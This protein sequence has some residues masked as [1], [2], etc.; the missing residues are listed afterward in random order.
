MRTIFK[1]AGGLLQSTTVSRKS[2]YAPLE[3][4]TP[5]ALLDNFGVEIL[6]AGCA[7]LDLVVLGAV[8][9]LCNDPFRWVRLQVFS[10]SIQCFLAK[11]LGCRSRTFV[12]KVATGVGRLERVE[13]EY[14]GRADKRTRTRTPRD[15]T[16]VY[17]TIYDCVSM[18]KS[19]GD[20]TI[21]ESARYTERQDLLIYHSAIKTDGTRVSITMT[22][23]YSILLVPIGSRTALV[24][25]T[26][27]HNVGVILPYQQRASCLLCS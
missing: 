22:D 10:A 9:K 1:M 11:D 12:T 15:T 18:Y 19:Q 20:F 2:H 3:E 23:V 17:F 24:L 6:A 21:I 16:N 5:R 4:K 26:L 25:R 13:S 8:R 14:T 7:S 27:L